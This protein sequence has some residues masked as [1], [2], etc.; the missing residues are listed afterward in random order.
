MVLTADGG[1][2]RLEDRGIAYD[3]MVQE[4]AERFE[5]TKVLRLF[6]LTAW[7]EWVMAGKQDLGTFVALVN[8]PL[9][10]QCCCSHRQVHHY[11]T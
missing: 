8:V 9:Q 6:V 1:P 7:N 3:Q 5:S 4:A 11:I 2:Y 10:Q